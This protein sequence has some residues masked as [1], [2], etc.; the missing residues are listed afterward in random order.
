MKP[1]P[2]VMSMVLI[3][4]WLLPP[5]RFARNVAINVQRTYQK[6]SRVLLCRFALRTCRLR[7]TDGGIL[8]AAVFHEGKFA[9]TNGTCTLLRQKDLYNGFGLTPISK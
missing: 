5:P 8:S 7:A 3:R 6:R 2:P 1:E 9:F 4:L